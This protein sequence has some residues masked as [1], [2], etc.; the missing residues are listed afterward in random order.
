MPQPTLEYY[1]L[2]RT[3]LE[4]GL[5][6]EHRFIRPDLRYQF[7]A[8]QGA[9]NEP[10]Q[11]R[12]TI[13]KTLLLS[14]F[15]QSSGKPHLTFAVKETILEHVR[16]TEFPQRISRYRAIFTVPS[17]ED[18]VIFRDLLRGQGDDRPHLHIC[19]IDGEVFTADLQYVSS[20]N[21]LAPMLKQV[22]YL[23]DRSRLYWDG[24]HSDTPILECLAEPGTVT[25]LAP[26][27]W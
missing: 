1:H 5:V 27:G 16:V 8:I 3:P 10:P 9:L 23:M 20:P 2:S 11:A 26:V 21:P 18:A 13:L 7:Q 15:V 14:D 24:K 17:R 12:A 22:E 25:V 4:S 19:R 6:L